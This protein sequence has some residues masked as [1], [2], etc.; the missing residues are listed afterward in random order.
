VVAKRKAL[1]DR[2]RG[3]L[4]G[5]DS[6]MTVKEWCLQWLE[7]SV[8]A[9]D[10]AES[11]KLKLER[12]L[13]GHVYAT[14]L[15]ATLLAKLR[16]QVVEGWLLELRNR[17]NPC[18]GTTHLSGFVSLKMCLDT[19][20]RD[21]L[22]AQNPMKTVTAPKASTK[23][24]IIPTM[25]ELASL[26]SE[27]SGSILHNAWV[28]I[29]AT[30]MRKGEC[31]ALEWDDIDLDKGSVSIRRTV[32][33]VTGGF[34]TR[35]PKTKA[36]KRV[37]YPDAGTID[38]LRQQ[39]RQVAKM[40][41]AGGEGWQ[42]SNLVFPTAKGTR[43]HPRNALRAYQT[44]AGRAGIERRIDIHSVRHF[45][46]TTMLIAGIDIKT[47]SKIL[48]HAGTRVTADICAHMTDESRDRAMGVLGAVTGFLSA[49]TGTSGPVAAGRTANPSCPPPLRS[50][51]PGSRIC[52]R[53]DLLTRRARRG[54]PTRGCGRRR[55]RRCGPPGEWTRTGEK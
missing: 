49:A 6:S 24:K 45:S 2:L 44:A 20:V 36:S 39:R 10:R 19:A 8:A 17:A 26:L 51:A 46:A 32:T 30:G 18:S 42:D 22:I 41:L 28:L 5:S 52:R 4:A 27:T 15:G 9:S 21:M 33:E 43:H 13:R 37:L 34:S 11:T 7:V 29:C 14:A 48:G 54:C 53:T 12:L 55:G 31:L 50:G 35:E 40:R 1:E 47:V 23:E 38:V 25:D 16:P 3:G